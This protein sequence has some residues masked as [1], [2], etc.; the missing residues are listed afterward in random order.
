MPRTVCCV[1]T[2]RCTLV[3]YISHCIRSINTP[4]VHV[5]CTVWKSS[6]THAFAQDIACESL[7]L[8]HSQDCE[9]P[10]MSLAAP[11]RHTLC[12]T[13]PGAVHL[14]PHVFLG[15]PLE[16]CPRP[17]TCLMLCWATCPFCQ[18]SILSFTFQSFRSLHPLCHMERGPFRLGLSSDHGG[19]KGPTDS[20]AHPTASCLHSVL[21]PKPGSI[22]RTRK[23]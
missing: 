13:H 23:V 22:T 17:V 11:V 2:G 18:P 15:L 8:A 5:A 16:P 3:I 1:Y 10:F 6:T 7:A 20:Q 9:V 21:D 19:L 4:C 12:R 14:P